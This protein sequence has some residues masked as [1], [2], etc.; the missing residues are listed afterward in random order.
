MRSFKV[1]KILSKFMRFNQSLWDLIKVYE[2][3][4]KLIRFYQS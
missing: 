3:L 4:S 1:N 2:I